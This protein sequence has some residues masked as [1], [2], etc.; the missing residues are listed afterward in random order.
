VKVLLIVEPPE[1]CITA[2]AL[3]ITV[4]TVQ[5]LSFFK[6]CPAFITAMGSREKDI[7]VLLHFVI[8]L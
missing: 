5:T 3:I 1:I 4:V 6:H 7:T 8:N 2:V